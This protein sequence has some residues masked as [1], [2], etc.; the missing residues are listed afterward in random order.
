MEEVRIFNLLLFIFAV[1]LLQY[2]KGYLG[3]ATQ[4]AN[5]LASGSNS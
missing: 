2:N 5:G 4:I 3:P 1:V